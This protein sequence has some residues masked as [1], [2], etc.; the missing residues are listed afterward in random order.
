VLKGYQV[1]FQQ[2]GYLVLHQGP[3]VTAVH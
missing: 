1:V 2:D 3:P